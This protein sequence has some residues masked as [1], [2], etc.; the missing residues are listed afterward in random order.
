LAW[1]LRIPKPF[2]PK[3]EL[4]I[5]VRLLRPVRSP[6]LSVADACQCSRRGLLLCWEPTPRRARSGTLESPRGRSRPRT[7][8]FWLQVP[9]RRSVQSTAERRLQRT[10]QMPDIVF[11]QAHK[12][13]WARLQLQAMLARTFPR[14]PVKP[15]H[16]PPVPTGALERAN[17]SSAPWNRAAES[18]LLTPTSWACPGKSHQP[19]WLHPRGLWSG[20]GGAPRGSSELGRPAERLRPGAVSN[21]GA[22]PETDKQDEEITELATEAE[23]PHPTSEPQPAPKTIPELFRGCPQGVEKRVPPRRRWTAPG[24]AGPSRTTERVPLATSFVATRGGAV[25]RWP[26]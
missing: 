16:P 26:R 3:S 17:E 12:A 10:F 18:E 6:T 20:S 15:Y 7:G 8:Y 11:S 13:R 4:A 25:I 21:R 19:L 14:H 5:V 9:G 1:P 22:H 24:P 2:P 23:R